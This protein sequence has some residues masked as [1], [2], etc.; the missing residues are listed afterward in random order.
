MIYKRKHLFGGSFSVSE[1]WIMI[2]WSGMWPQAVRY[3]ARSI[4]E[5][6]CPVE[7]GTS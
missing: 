5:N 2:T 6:L 1:S 3:G 4:A 7:L